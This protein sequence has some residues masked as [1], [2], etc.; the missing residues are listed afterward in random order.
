MVIEESGGFQCKRRAS[1]VFLNLWP[2]NVL[3]NRG[4]WRIPEQT[5][6]FWCLPEVARSYH[7]R[8]LKL[9]PASAEARRLVSRSGGAPIAPQ[10][11]QRHVLA[12]KDKDMSWQT[13]KKRLG[14]QGK[15][16]SW[17]TN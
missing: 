6:C 10:Q 1:E 15:N 5:S 16:M 2:M 12:D 17:Q 14:R 4:V 7:G 11:K 13:R 9:S 8:R 3:A